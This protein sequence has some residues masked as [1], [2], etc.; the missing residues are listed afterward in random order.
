MF[1]ELLLNNKGERYIIQIVD[2]NRMVTNK[3]N[4]MKER[5]Y[6]VVKS[7]EMLQK[8]RYEL[9]LSEYKL[10]NYIVSKI[11]P[12]SKKGDKYKIDLRD[13]C[14][15]A[16]ISTDGGFHFAE[17]KK[18]LKSLR[19]KSFWIE[20][21]KQATLCSWISK[22]TIDKGTSVA[23]IELDDII[24]NYFI[25]LQRDFTQYELLN[26]LALTSKY[27]LRLY[28]YLRSFISDD[29][30]KG[31]NSVIDITVSLE[32]LNSVLQHTFLYNDLRRRV[33]EPS[34]KE[35][36]SY[37]DII[38]NYEPIKTGRSVSHIRFTIK[39]KIA[40]E[41]ARKGFVERILDKNNN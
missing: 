41:D 10:M 1:F 37:T 29:K 18:S 34:L 32:E 40:G 27:S 9:S 30:K 13:Y 38:F 22:V 35:I 7:K 33:L 4:V 16:G 14:E 2:I 39:K 15:I 31:N 36:L 26:T 6:K 12:Y 3:E 28:D 24:E 5:N 19:D 8:G 17:I 11:T 20:N 23:L 25:G 21:E